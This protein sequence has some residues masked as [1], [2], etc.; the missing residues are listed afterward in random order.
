MK[1]RSLLKPLVLTVTLLVVF[2]FVLIAPNAQRA[3]V[4]LQVEDR[5]FEVRGTKVGGGGTGFQLEAPS[6][7]SYI[8]TNSHVCEMAQKDSKDN[9]FLLIHK[10]DHW[11]KRR[12]LEI[13]S[14]S[15]L[16]LVEG[17]PGLSGLSIGGMA[18]IGDLVSAIGH[19]RLGPTTTSLGEIVAFTDTLMVHH[20]M[21]LGDTKL[22][23]LLETSDESCDQLKNEIVKKNM[24][25]FSPREVSWCMVKENEAIQ[26]NV[27]IFPGSSGSPLISSW[28]HVVGVMFASDTTT[29]W[30]YA[31]NLRYLNQLLKDF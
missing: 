16:C 31:V 6:G 25:L 19:P 15:D 13:S 27:V 22:D 17:W 30:G 2:V 21:P 18:H 5:I 1:L 29:H 7:V 26:T 28:G 10:N 12:I 23:K 3:W 8:V 20:L 11:M 9:T 4:R 24:I 14:N